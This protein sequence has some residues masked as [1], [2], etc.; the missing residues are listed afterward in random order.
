LLVGMVAAAWFK[1]RPA[2]LQPTIAGM[3]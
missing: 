1:L 3:D 2:D